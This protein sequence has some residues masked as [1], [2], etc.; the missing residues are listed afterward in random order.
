MAD[1]GSCLRLCVVGAPWWLLRGRQGS[2]RWRWGRVRRRAAGLCS[3]T[4]S[5]HKLFAFSLMGRSRAE[6]G[7]PLLADRYSVQ[8]LLSVSAWNIFWKIHVW[9]HNIYF[10]TSFHITLHNPF[11]ALLIFLYIICCLVLWRASSWVWKILFLLQTK[12][13]FVLNTVS[14]FYSPCPHFYSPSFFSSKQ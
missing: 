5:W 3:R 14:Y 4:V 13:R 6:Q 12:L 1:H 7:L 8:C 2:Q 11:I 10:W 9:L